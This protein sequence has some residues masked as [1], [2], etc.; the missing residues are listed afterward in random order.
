M[1]KMLV[2]T[3]K[4]N[5]ASDLAQALGGFRKAEHGW[6]RDDVVIS[7]ARGHLVSLQMPL[8]A[9]G[10]KNLQQ[11]PV[12]GEFVTELIDKEGSVGIYRNLE[13]LM[14]RSDIS[15][16]VNACDA[17]REGELIF[18]LIIEHA[19]CKKPLKRMWIQSMTTD[20]FKEAFRSMRPAAEFDSL[21][22]AAHA[23][24]IADFLVGIN[25]SRAITYMRDEQSSAGRVQT[26]TGMLLYD[27]EMAIRNFKPTDYWEIHATFQA[28][29]G[30]YLGKWFDPSKAKA[31]LDEESAEA[32]DAEKAEK[33]DAA[34][35]MRIFDRSVAEA[36]IAKCR[37]KNPSSV[38]DTG[39]RTKRSAPDLYNQD[40]LQ[41]DANRRFKFT[42]KKTLEIAQALYDEHK[43]TTYPRTDSEALPEDYGDAVRVR[44]KN[45]E[46]TP[47]AVHG[48][49][50]LE[51]GWV[52]PADKGIFNNAKISDHFAIIPTEKSPVGV[53]LSDD[54]RKIYDLI[55]RRF[56]AAF[57][58]A[59]EF[60][61]TTRI[62][63]IEGESFKTTGSVMVKEGWLAVYGQD[64]SSSKKESPLVAVKSGEA[65]KTVDVKA[66]TCQTKPPPRYNDGTLIKAMV[67]AGKD[68]D[69]KAMREA[70]KGR[71][72]GTVATRAD[73]IEGLLSTGPR[74]KPRKPYAV[75]E[76]DFIVPTDKLM[77]LM[78]FIRKE[79]IELLAS[80]E[81]TG[82]WEYKL[83]LVQ[84]GEL[85]STAFLDGIKA[86]VANMLDK[87]RS[88][89]SSMPAISR[90]VLQVPCPKC[91]EPLAAGSRTVDCQ[92]GC[93]FKVW[94]EVSNKTLSE[95]EL[96]TL[97]KEGS[98]A[99]LD[100]FISKAKRKYSAGLKFDGE[101]IEMVFE[102]RGERA[103]DAER[104]PMSALPV[105]GAPC[106]KCKGVI[107]IHG[108][109]RPKFACEKGDFTLWRVIAQRELSESEATT[110]ITH[111]SLSAVSGFI[112]SKTGK[113]FAAALRMSR[114]KSKVD[115]DFGK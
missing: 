20:G 2:I 37:G 104:P 114:D 69:D 58:P 100:G 51:N 109:D 15:T 41:Q 47:Y 10:G 8:A 67:N 75:R 3:E 27:R 84:K 96:N 30:Q 16:V 25:G 76:K 110:L 4:S 80:A 102:D 66:V 64:A 82:E 18:R 115:F 12:A 73:T 101:K 83:G 6:E 40:S 77:S 74:A 94:R 99:K 87:I 57:H 108:G 62:S 85:S 49:R 71:G 113:P 11:L 68:I 50:V 112:S 39:K 46:G 43:L 42:A 14:K 56:M 31:K 45:F 17:G 22:D 72:L 44:M 36:I 88:Q 70:M 28:E 61:V 65:V 26:P 35:G 1:G 19:G 9:T 98:I 13:K 38:I 5:V 29:A 21:S 105:L 93:G 91:G 97:L 86:E 90:T 79:K 92:A 54:E 24:S 7:N 95:A 33:Q 34:S 53:S 81:T 106:P 103:D 55:V 107:R 78:G 89:A 32:E 59:A 63:V 60:D 48:Q 23:R 52:N 111:G